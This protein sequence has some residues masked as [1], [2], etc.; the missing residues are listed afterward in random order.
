MEEIMER[1]CVSENDNIHIY[2]T[3]IHELDCD[4]DSRNS[5]VVN[6]I[7]DKI[8]SLLA[9]NENINFHVHTDRMKISH[10]PRYKKLLMLFI[11]IVTVKYSTT[12]LNKCYLY[13]VNRAMKILLDIVKPFLL[14]AVKSNMVVVKEILDDKDD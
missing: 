11:Q 8:D 12:M 2:P 10:T 13:D 5:Y 7:L 4:E 9:I 1:I 14:P 3:R 6:Y